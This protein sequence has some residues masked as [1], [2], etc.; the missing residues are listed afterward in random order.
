VTKQKLN[1]ITERWLASLQQPVREYIE[2]MRETCRQFK[3]ERDQAY[4]SVAAAQKI[5]R[6]M[7]L[8]LDRANRR[9]AELESKC[10]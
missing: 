1:R 7:R 9:I 2:N 10:R 6:D 5:E 8:E 4:M 3:E